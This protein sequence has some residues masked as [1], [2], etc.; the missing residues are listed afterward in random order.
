MPSCH[1]RSRRY[2]RIASQLASVARAPAQVR[3]CVAAASQAAMCPQVVT[4]LSLVAHGLKI[5]L[6]SDHISC[7]F[8]ESLCW[9][10]PHDK[11]A[12][13]Y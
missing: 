13:L 6:S 4:W 5:S 1:V 12:Q 8:T 3:R 11:Y 9:A 2:A 7:Y 10:N